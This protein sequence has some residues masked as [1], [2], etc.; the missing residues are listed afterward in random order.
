MNIV[1]AT[2]NLYSHPALVTI[3]SLLMN[4]TEADEIGIH[5]I[6]NGISEDNKKM[7]TE[8]VENFG[9]KIVFYPMPESLREIK[10]LSRTDPVVYSYCFL[11]EILPESIDRALLLE[12][13]CI[14]ADSLQELYS[15][16]LTGCCLAASDDGQSKWYKRK[17]GLKDGSVYHN[18]GVLLFN[19]AEMRKIGF[20]EK[21]RA[22]IEAGNSKFFYE[23]QDELN[24]AL[25]GRIKTIPPR[26]NCTTALFLFDYKNMLRYRRPSTVCTEE[27]FRTARE[28]PVV[29]H[30]TKNQII[31]ARPWIRD[32]VHPYNDLYLRI[33]EGTVLRDE[34]LWESG[35]G[36]INR[37][38]CRVYEKA[39]KAL[40]AWGLG[41]VHA[42][43]YPVFLYRIMM[44][45]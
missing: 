21:I 41:L 43:L 45:K 32:C 27:E 6:G 24:A 31:Q 39:P 10:G 14:V 8:L 2:S 13:D 20:T 7:L 1:M 38:A 37:L 22:V 30:F 34:P 11:Q 33:K 4:N 25:E 28:H 44:K 23:V 15:T 16:D 3:R 40:T 19:L 12:A 18:S 26:F 5:Y 17:L 42:F 9:R 29:I 36:R 35:R